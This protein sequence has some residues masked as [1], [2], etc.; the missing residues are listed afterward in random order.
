C[1]GTGEARGL[2]NVRRLRVTVVAPANGVHKITAEP[3][4][5]AI[6]SFEIEIDSLVLRIRETGLDPQ[7]VVVL[8]VPLVPLAPLAPLVPLIGPQNR[9]AKKRQEHCR[10]KTNDNV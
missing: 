7:R 4:Q 5:G 1:G 9:N 2:V 3:D 10:E 8:R 6:S